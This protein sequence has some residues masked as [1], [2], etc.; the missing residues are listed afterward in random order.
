MN[1]AIIPTQRSKYDYS[2]LIEKKQHEREISFKSFMKDKIRAFRLQHQDDDS[3]S[4]TRK[5]LAKTINSV[6]DSNTPYD[7]STLTKIINGRQKT[8][9]RDLIIAICFALELNESETNQALSLYSMAPLNPNDLR[10]LVI[11]HALRDGLTVSELNDVLKQHG[12][13]SLNIIRGQE[14]EDRPLKYPYDS[15]KYYER[16]VSI[17]PYDIAEEDSETSRCDRYLRERYRLDRFDY[18]C[19]MVVCD[20]GGFGPNY[21]ITMDGGCN[22][23]ISL[24]LKKDEWKLMYSN[25]A[26][27]QKYYLVPQ[28]EDADLL[29]EVSKLKEYRDRRARYVHSVC[30]DTRNYGTRLDAVIDNGQ[31]VVYGEHFGY[32]APE[33]SEYYQ[34]T[35]SSTD[36]R[37]SISNNSLFMRRYLGE[38]EWMK[39]YGYVLP[40]VNRTFTSIEDVPDKRWRRQ[41]NEL[42]ASASEMLKQLQQ[43]ELFL[44]YVHDWG[45]EDYI[46][47]YHVEDAVLT[48]SFPIGVSNEFIGKTAV[49]SVKAGT[50]LAICEF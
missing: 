11:E 25:D 27:T 17:I 35:V 12:F 33:L 30:G 28:C 46:H 49:I 39:Q 22:Y 16:D 5:T 4:I 38:E 18:H 47:I 3:E 31:L 34:I 9:R 14:K 42:M 48:N 10:D 36:F 20:K 15:T 41:F 8:R 6:L 32:D 50:L 7:L 44:N 13:S 23:E 21:Q 24:E 1:S 37:L 29:N 2:W 19:N 26:S 43:R 45:I 40:P